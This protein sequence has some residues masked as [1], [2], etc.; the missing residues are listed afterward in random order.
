MELWLCFWLYVYVIAKD[1]V[2]IG[3]Y[4]VEQTGG[5]VCV[6]MFLVAWSPWFWGD[7]GVLTFMIAKMIFLVIIHGV[8]PAKELCGIFYAAGNASDIRS[9]YRIY[10]TW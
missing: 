7:I 1:E 3:M 4:K 6:M 8:L 10:E 2:V 5:K 9:E